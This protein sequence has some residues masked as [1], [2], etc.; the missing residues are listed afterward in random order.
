MIFKLAIPGN[1]VVDVLCDTN[2][3]HD[4]KIVL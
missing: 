3:L 1:S 4:K 2:K